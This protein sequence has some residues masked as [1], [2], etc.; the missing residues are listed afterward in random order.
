MLRHPG[1]EIGPRS[2]GVRSGLGDRGPLHHAL[3]EAVDQFDTRNGVPIDGAEVDAAELTEIEVERPHVDLFVDTDALDDLG[4]EIGLG[5]PI[6]EHVGAAE[7]GL[8]LGEADLGAELDDQQV[9]DE[10]EE[11]LDLG[12]DLG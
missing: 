8:G 7:H 2:L 10:G 6:D 1:P 3:P 5:P 12:S 4:G 11:G 9:G